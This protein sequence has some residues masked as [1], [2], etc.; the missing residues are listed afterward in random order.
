MTSKFKST[1]EVLK[2]KTNAAKYHH[3]HLMKKPC[4]TSYWQTKKDHNYCNVAKP[5]MPQPTIQSGPRPDLGLKEAESKTLL[6]TQATELLGV[7]SSEATCSLSSQDSDSL[8]GFTAG[9]DIICQSLSPFLD[10]HTSTDKPFPMHDKELTMLATSTKTK[11]CNSNVKETTAAEEINDISEID[12]E[13]INLKH[14]R[15]SENDSSFHLSDQSSQ[16]LDETIESESDAS[17]GSVESIVSE[18]K[19]IVFESSLNSLLMKVS[20]SQCG[21]PINEFN[22]YIVG[23]A[24]VYY[25]HCL[26]SHVMPSWS[27]QPFLGKM[28]AG[29]L[30][31]SVATFFSGETYTHLRNFAK[32]MNLQFIGHSQYYQMKSNLIIPVV[33]ET[34]DKHIAE[35][36]NEIRGVETWFSGDA[37]F[38]SP[39]FSAKYGSYSLMAQISKKIVNTELVHVSEAGSSQACE[40]EGFIPCRNHLKEKGIPFELLATD[41]HPS[42]SKYMRELNEEDLEYDLWH[43]AK[44]LKKKPTLP[45][46]KKEGLC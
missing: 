9:Q 32:F 5:D 4:K 42:I 1:S 23:T 37:R 43:V 6:N 31:C 28:P 27:S 17:C 44:S 22:K 36:Q 3:L 29:N 13:N 12:N 25:L 21:K 35:V 46:I 2:L 41:R 14:A 18:R 40:K 24:V 30:L 39:G 10:P 11:S 33:N 19:F 26:N 38:D 20:C 7:I 34:Y 15:T 8:K 16:S 45:G